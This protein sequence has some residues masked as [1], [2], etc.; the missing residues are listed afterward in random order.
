MRNHH[1]STSPASRTRPLDHQACPGWGEA[2]HSCAWLRAAAASREPG[3]GGRLLSSWGGELSPAQGSSKYPAP[4][5][6]APSPEDGGLVWTGLML[7]AEGGGE[8]DLGMEKEV[9]LS[10]QLSQ[11]LGFAGIKNNLPDN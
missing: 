9:P 3:V 8:G 10:T 11:L 5:S 6:S 4:Q 1:F 2:A 7:P